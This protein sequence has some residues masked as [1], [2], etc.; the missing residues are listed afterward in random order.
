GLAAFGNHVFA[1]KRMSWKITPPRVK[2]IHLLKSEW[3][4]LDAPLSLIVG[5]GGVGKTTISAALGFHARQKSRR[6][7]E[8]CSVDPAP[9][10]DDVFETEVA[11]EPVL[12]LCAT[13]FRPSELFWVR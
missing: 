9:S 6:A 4:A 7:V 3:P 8:I 12:L 2:D 13:G 1:G 10:L 5:K 11:Y